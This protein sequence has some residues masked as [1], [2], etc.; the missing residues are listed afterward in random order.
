MKWRTKDD[1]VAW[2]SNRSDHVSK[3]GLNVGFLLSVLHSNSYSM[4]DRENTRTIQMRRGSKV[5][6]IDDNFPK[7]VVNFYTH[8]P[9]KNAQ[10]MVRDVGIGV[11][12]NGDPEIVVYLKDMPNPN[13][14]T[15]PYPERGFNQERFRE[16]EEPP[17]EAEEI[18]VED[19]L[20]V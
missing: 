5:V 6:C 12:W 1:Q 15:P 18:E 3:C 16:I 14:S 8:L 20:C 9:V 7:E 17:L 4:V 13:S 19:E 11:G 10:Y 2:R